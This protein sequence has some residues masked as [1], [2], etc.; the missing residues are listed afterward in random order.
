MA[1]V[2]L[3]IASVVVGLTAVYLAWLFA[4]RSLA[5]DTCLDRGGSFDYSQGSCALDSTSTS[6]AGIGYGALPALIAAGAAVLALMLWRRARMPSAER[7]PN[8]SL[9]RSRER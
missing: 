6:Q 9:E 5:V 2:A 1:S 4:S 3:R 8:N 7:R